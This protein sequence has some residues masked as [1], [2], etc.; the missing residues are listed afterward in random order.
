MRLARRSSPATAIVSIRRQNI[1]SN[2]HGENIHRHQ[3]SVSSFSVRS[4]STIMSGRS[5]VQRLPLG[6]GHEREHT[7]SKHVSKIRLEAGG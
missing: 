2:R 3:I 7:N 5:E 1:N 6:K 4:L